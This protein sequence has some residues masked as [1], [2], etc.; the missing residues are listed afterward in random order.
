MRTESWTS[1]SRH[2]LLKDM[3]SLPFQVGVKVQ[4]FLY[5]R[6]RLLPYSAAAS[7]FT[8]SGNKLGPDTSVCDEGLGVGLSWPEFLGTEPS[9]KLGGWEGTRAISSSC[10]CHRTSQQLCIAYCLPCR[11][12]GA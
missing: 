4:H 1:L 5:L 10:V 2:K 11:F 8:D 6:V 7:T 9:H 3:S 12:A